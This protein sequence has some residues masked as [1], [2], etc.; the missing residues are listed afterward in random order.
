[1]K[2][3]YDA[4]YLLRRDC[5]RALERAH[6]EPDALNERFNAD[7]PTVTV[8]TSY[9]SM[10]VKFLAY[11][12]AH[13]VGAPVTIYRVE[14]EL[15]AALKDDGTAWVNGGRLRPLGRIE[16]PDGDRPWRRP[17]SYFN[18]S[19]AAEEY[20]ERKVIPEID[21]ALRAA[22][23]ADAVLA[24]RHQA[25][26]RFVASQRGEIARQVNDILGLTGK[27][28]EA[29]SELDSTLSLLNDSLAN[30]RKAS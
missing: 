3:I 13:I 16:K 11:N 10:P 27:L 21:R 12:D 19:R 26:H 18:V 23:A 17:L 5:D 2:S 1:M 28:S 14:Y 7:L 24:A 25:Q 22:D 29:V 30:L 15:S 6:R 9:G 20:A 4:L 8:E